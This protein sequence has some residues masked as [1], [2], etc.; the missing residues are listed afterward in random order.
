MVH[1][2]PVEKKNESSL[3]PGQLLVIS[4]PEKSN[5]NPYKVSKSRLFIRL[6]SNS[7]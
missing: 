7:I 1:V 6:D 4:P 2:S 3:S 5:F